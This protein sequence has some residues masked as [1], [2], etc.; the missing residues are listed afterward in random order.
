MGKTDL[1]YL[2]ILPPFK[3][4]TQ[5]KFE[6]LSDNITNLNLTKNESVFK[7]GEEGDGFYVIKSGMVRV[8]IE[9]P[10]SGEKIILSNLSE[11]DYFGEM[12]LLTN[13]PRSASIE[14]ITNVSLL[15]LDKIGFDRIL[16]EDPKVSIAISHMLSQ[17]LMQ[18]NLQRVASEQFYQSKIS[19]SG[20]LE[21]YNIL[22]V[23]KFCEENSLTGKLVLVKDEKSAQ[24]SF[25]KGVV[26]KVVMGDLGDAEAMDI[27]TQWKEG[28]FKI[29]PTLFSMD[30]EKQEVKEEIVEEK[31]DSP[32]IT[33][34]KTEEIDIIPV[35]EEFLSNC[36]SRLIDLIGSQ[37]MNEEVARA[38]EKCIP[39][40]PVLEQCNFDI[41]PNLEIKLVFNGKWT[42]K[43][44]LAIAVFLESII[45]NCQNLVYGMSY[46]DLEEIAGEKA[47][48]LKSISFFEYMENAKEFTF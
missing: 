10:E 15:R 25:L 44:T 3:D 40:F 42:E 41:L 35:L 5:E 23:L 11:G 34:A 12:A 29:E 9:A 48:H 37:P 43:E 28:R 1:E 16:E 2:R 24:I 17:R 22:D 38:K 7:V 32:E 31:P 4:L 39:Y 36:F 18:A 21:D 45:K 33:P 20:S 6:S 30:E 8:Y 13:G 27:L 19:P 14:T 26:Q 46:F 47:N